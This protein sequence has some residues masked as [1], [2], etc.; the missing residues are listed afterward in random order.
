MASTKIQKLETKI[1]AKNKSTA[2][3]RKKMQ[4]EGYIANFLVTTPI[5][6]AVAGAV[7]AKW[8]KDGDLSE[9]A[10]IGPVP[11]NLVVGFG[12]AVVG[13]IVP[14][15]YRMIGAPIQ[16]LG[17]GQMAGAGYRAAFDKMSE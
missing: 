13:A 12:V 11:T 8:P 16:G 2:T 17:Q 10:M 6:G 5:G 7:D 4:A 14:T 9:P 15:K 1:A 3:F